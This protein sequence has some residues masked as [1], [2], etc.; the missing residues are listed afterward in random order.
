MIA[1]YKKFLLEDPRRLGAVHGR[2]IFLAAFGK[3]PGWD[4]HIED[5]GLDT[6]SLVQAKQLL[7][8]E[9]IGGAIDSGAWEKLEPDRQI[10]LF[11]H[12]FLWRRA[13]QFLLGRLWSS[14]DGKGRERYPMIVCAHVIGLPLDW[15]VQHVL[16][17]L[18]EIQNACQTARTAAEVQA[19]LRRELDALRQ[20]LATTP[21]EPGAIDRFA[22]GRERFL[23]SPL[24]EANHQGLLR[25]LHQIRSQWTT[26]TNPKGLDPN[27]DITVKP[28]QIRVATA[29]QSP[30]EALV[31]WSRFFNLPLT[32]G[33]PLLL[34][35]PWEESW[36]DAIVGEPTTQ[37]LFCLRASPKTVPLANSIPY[38]LDTETKQR[39]E[40]IIS[41]F[42]RGDESLLDG[43]GETNAS[44]GRHSILAGK[45]QTKT[46]IKRWKSWFGFGGFSLVVILAT[47]IFR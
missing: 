39:S 37:E 26:Y 20:S 24:W 27:G 13:G 16:P 6:E 30:D 41:A 38:N 11:K 45:S 7:Y 8:L 14:K 33:T 3:H 43:A 25:I 19:I 40:E 4:D 29:A 9:G 44:S 1:F 47:S 34:L 5:I 10:P 42:Q 35:L 18:A 2:Q 17:R 32:P 31:L 28:Q 21:L 12:L 23:A 15:A 36:V 22:P 46:G